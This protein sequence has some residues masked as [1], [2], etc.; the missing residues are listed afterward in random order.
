MTLLKKYTKGNIGGIICLF[1]AMLMLTFG[2]ELKNGV[3][4]GLSISYNIIIPTLFPFFILSDLWSQSL[5]VSPDSLLGKA[6]KKLFGINGA[7][8]SAFICGMFCGFP[9]G[10]KASVN[11]YELGKINRDEA[12]LLCAL[13]SNPS[14]A[15]V[16]SGIG[17]GMYGS[18]K[19]GILLYFC[20]IISAVIAGC[21]F[22]LKGDD[23]HFYCDNSGQL[24]NLVDSIRNA[25]LSSITVS[26]YIIFFSALTAL[27]RSICKIKALSITFVCLA[28][29]SSACLFMKEIWPSPT[30]ASLAITAF[31]LGF[32]GFSVHMQAFSFVPREIS[33]IKFLTTKFLV[34]VVSSILVFIVSII[35]KV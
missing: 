7:G 6:F 30:P 17:L 28:E 25:G 23:N 10:V 24:F 16:I 18:I 35:L 4:D 8:A 21:I 14:C 31:A 27:F 3:K 32:S 33:R 22:R 1:A 20:V 26:S 2:N 15:F 13:A 11:S 29:I 34:G 5:A 9:I 19:I 12:Q